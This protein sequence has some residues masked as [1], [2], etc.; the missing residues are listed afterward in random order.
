MQEFLKRITPDYLK[1]YIR[2]YKANQKKKYVESLHRLTQDEVYSVLKDKAE[3]KKGDVAFIHSSVDYLNIDFPFYNIIPMLL[4]IVGEEGTILFPTYPKLTSY[5]FLKSGQIFDVRRTPTYTGLINEFARRYK[6]AV[7]SLHPT[8]SCVAIG[9]YAEDL[10]N[11][12]QNSPYPYSDQSPY[13]KITHYDGKII[14][15]G[16]DRTFISFVHCIDDALKEKFPVKVYHDELLTGKCKDYE[17]KLV[18]V[19]TY[20]HNMEMMYFDLPGFINKYISNEIVKDINIDGNKFYR[21]FS[22]PLFD[23][24]FRLASEENITFYPKKFYR[25]NQ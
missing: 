5:K 23:E 25:K 13:F 8:K 2:T 20:A 1:K 16:V 19:Q 3:L 9:K 7:R 11:T 4:D 10:T 24:M 22:K 21:A 17:G 18:D 14:G 12:H 6:G 15:I